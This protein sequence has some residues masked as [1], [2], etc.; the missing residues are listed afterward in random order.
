[1]KKRIIRVSC[2]IS[3]TA[4]LVAGCGNA[5]IKQQEK[6]EESQTQETQEKSQTQAEMVETQESDIKKA[7]DGKKVP[8]FSTVDLDGNTVTDD[9]FAEKDLTVLNVW[10]TYCGPCINEMPELGQWAEE[11]PDNVQLIGLICDGYGNEDTAV[12]ITEKAGANYLQLIANEDFAQFFETIVGVP[13]TYFVDKNGN[14][15]GEPIIGAYVEGY[16][17]FVEDYF[18]E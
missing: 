14:I 13:T 3:M 5:V 16:K 15:V 17:N 11:L 18:N 10:G 8:S 2:M 1:M 4:L 7:E 9:I 6:G 12:Q